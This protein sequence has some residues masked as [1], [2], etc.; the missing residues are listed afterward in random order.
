VTFI[1]RGEVHDLLRKAKNSQGAS[2]SSHQNPVIVSILYIYHLFTET[3]VNSVF[4]GSET[5]VVAQGETE[6]N[7]GGRGATKHAGVSVSKCIIIYIASVKVSI[8]P[9]KYS[10]TAIK[11]SG[12]HAEII[13]NIY[14]HAHIQL[15]RKKIQER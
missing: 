7:N 13:I 9:K 2:R 10:E 1:H 5:A 3:S 8:I 12:R 14:L 4:C 15:H 6:G 11:P